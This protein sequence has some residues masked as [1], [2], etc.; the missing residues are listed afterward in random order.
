MKKLKCNESL[1]DN[2]Q[3]RIIS[4]KQ[5]KTS[6]TEENIKK[7]LDK[8]NLPQDTDINDF[9]DFRNQFGDNVKIYNDY[10]KFK[11]DNH[12]TW[13]RV[14]NLK[15]REILENYIELANSKEENKSK[16]VICGHRDIEITSKIYNMIDKTN[17]N[18]K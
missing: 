18:V 1:W 15:F 6:L 5:R 17:D 7:I 4:F 8:Y 11:E 3:R 14:K 2:K 12:L 16:I 9:L 10:K 13:M